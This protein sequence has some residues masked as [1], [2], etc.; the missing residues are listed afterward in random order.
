MNRHLSALAVALCLMP[1]WLSAQTASNDAPPQFTINVASANVY[2]FPTMGSPVI[3]HANRGTV[4]VVTREL[5]SWVRVPWQGGE[6]GV[7]YL[8]VSEGTVSHGVAAR[9]ASTAT[10]ATN[11]GS[12][13]AQ[14]IGAQPSISANASAPAAQ[15]GSPAR[16]SQASM[17]QGS[18]VYVPPPV[19]RFGL[20]ALMGVSPS[21]IGASARAWSS[22]RFGAQ[23]AISHQ[24]EDHVDGELSSILF[25]PSLVYALRPGMSDYVSFRPYVGGGPSFYSHSLTDPLSGTDSS[26]SGVGFQAFGGGELTFASLPQVAVSVDLRF[27]HAGEPF[28]GFDMTGIG[29][30]AGAH[31]YFR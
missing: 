10:P 12:S 30:A 1:S 19:H 31:W 15:P 9:Q 3:A 11:P 2:K 7:A 13:A 18:A 27:H 22:R 14:A 29:V 16:A 4:L 23:F 20:G 8:H 25:S 24:S 17:A 6:D 21:E 28:P 5:G 26:K